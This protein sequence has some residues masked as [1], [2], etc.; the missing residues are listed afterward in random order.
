M[1][2]LEELVCLKYDL[3]KIAFDK[4]LGSE[5]RNELKKNLILTNSLIKN[6]KNSEQ[7]LV[8]EKIDL[9]KDYVLGMRKG[10]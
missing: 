9:L 8:T 6:I 2:N 10:R 3:V 5:S 4:S 7:V 1:T